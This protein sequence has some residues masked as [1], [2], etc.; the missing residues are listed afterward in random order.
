MEEKKESIEQEQANVEMEA[1]EEKVK[2]QKK[3]HKIT[4]PIKDDSAKDSVSTLSIVTTIV[5]DIF[6]V[7]GTVFLGI[8]DK[9]K[10]F[11]ELIV[12]AERYFRWGKDQGELS[13]YMNAIDHCRR[14]NDEDAEKEKLLIRKYKVFLSSLI[15][16]IEI[17]EKEFQSIFYEQISEYENL[18]NK[19]EKTKKR[20]EIN[21]EEIRQAYINGEE[22]TA[23]EKERMA[24]KNRKSYCNLL[25]ERNLFLRKKEFSEQFDAVNE[26]IETL[27]TELNKVS[28]S[29]NTL[30]LLTEENRTLLTNNL[31]DEFNSI[32]EDLKMFSPY[33][34][35]RKLAE[36][37]VGKEELLL[38]PEPI[39]K[40]DENGKPYS[41]ILAQIKKEKKDCKGVK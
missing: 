22:F 23:E 1:T 6:R 4:L 35:R 32:L 13:D 31:E 38:N 30:P 37:E 34:L 9:S 16:I 29:L 2:P 19:L 36:S 28:S 18:L 39:F 33:N 5:M 7:V 26:S 24:D 17:S 27:H 12:V 3:E 25:L 41:S 11:T 20:M 10:N 8:E 40:T 14:A 21:T 15:A